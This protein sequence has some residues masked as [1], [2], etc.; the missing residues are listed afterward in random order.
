LD[1]L[2]VYVDNF[3]S[4]AAFKTIL[5]DD[6]MTIDNLVSTCIKRFG[7]ENSGTQYYSVSL[8]LNQK[9]IKLNRND[10]VKAAFS[11]YTSV[12]EQGTGKVYISKEIRP[13]KVDS[14]SVTS[15]SLE[16]QKRLSHRVSVMEASSKIKTDM[17]LTAFDIALGGIYDY[18][19][20]QKLDSALRKIQD[21][22]SQFAASEST[23]EKKLSLRGKMRTKKQ[24]EEAPS[25]NEYPVEEIK[26]NLELV[27]VL[28]KNLE[29]ILVISIKMCAA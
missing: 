24:L 29:A 14:K 7:L 18:K 12:I 21:C 4:R 9:R 2:K 27:K 8:A 26:E 10:L 25:E 1:L 5:L 23:L 17:T 22:Q 13:A 3:E 16:S 6:T 15:E 19:Y 28:Q 11:K 20:A